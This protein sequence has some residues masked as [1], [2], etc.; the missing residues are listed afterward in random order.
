MAE[1]NRTPPLVIG[2]T[3]GSGTRLIAQLCLSAGY[4]LGQ[5]LNGALDA[6]NFYDFY[7]RWLTPYLSGDL[8]VMQQHNLQR[9]MLALVDELHTEVPPE[10]RQRW[11]W[12][13]PRSVLLLPLL[14]QCITGL[15][16]IHVIR[17]GRDMAY[18]S[19]QNQLRK[20]GSALLSPAQ[21]AQSEPL[22]SLAFW[23]TT[24]LRAAEYGTSY[25]SER[26]LWLRYEDVVNNRPA[27][28]KALADFLGLEAQQPALLHGHARPAPTVGRWREQPDEERR[29]LNAAGETGLRLFGYLSA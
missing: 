20:H 4:H 15:R 13:T 27:T 28:L 19:N 8:D 16:F 9:E 23:Q 5:R 11:G 21:Q 12:K 18:S 22:Q 7:D 26:Y 29:L 6:L 25:M 14:D 10:C 1:L 2:G 24:N 17:D 3:G